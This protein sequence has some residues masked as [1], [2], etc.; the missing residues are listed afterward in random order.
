MSAPIHFKLSELV[1][2]LAEIISRRLFAC[3]HVIVGAL[4]ELCRRLQSIAAPLNRFLVDGR[5]LTVHCVGPAA[6]GYRAI[7]LDANLNFF[8]NTAKREVV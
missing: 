7:W 8:R 1:I 5:Q 3:E 2:T 6:Q 4:G